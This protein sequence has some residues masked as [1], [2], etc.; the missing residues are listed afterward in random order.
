MR[1]YHISKASM[2]RLYNAFG[3]PKESLKG[4][5]RR[6]QTRTLN[7]KLMKNQ[8][9]QNYRKY[10]LIVQQ[11]KWILM[12]ITNFIPFFLPND[13]KTFKPSLFF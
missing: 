10:G 8:S 6:P 4:I 13:K 5:S 7:H 3:G 12:L 1:K 9:P 2:I 11:C